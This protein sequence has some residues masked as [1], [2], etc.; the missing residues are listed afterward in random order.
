MPEPLVGAFMAATVFCGLCGYQRRRHRSAWFAGFWICSAFACLTKGLLG[1][2]YPATIFLLLSIFYREARLRYRA[3]LRW[4]YLAIFLLIAAPWHIWTQWKFPGY[5]HYLIVREWEGHLWGLSD[6]LRDY[7]GVPVYQFVLMH[8]AWWFPWSIALLPGMIFAW[9]RV[10]R[11]HEIYFGDAL[12]LCW[13]GV[14]FVPLLFLGQRQDYYSMSMWS[15]FALWAA[16]AWGR[17]PQRWRIAGTITVAVSGVVCAAAAFF[18]ARAARPLNG[19]WGTMD[20]RWTAW[21]ALHDM[22]VSAWLASWPLLAITGSSLVLFSLVALYFVFEQREKLAAIALAISM[23]PCGLAMMDGVARVAPYFSL[24]NVAR[25][26]N[27]RLEAGGDTIFEGPLEESSSL[28]FY[29]NRKF[30]LV[31]QNRQKAAPLGTPPVDIFLNEYAV[32]RK[33]AQPEAVYLIVEQS[34]ADYW[35]QLLTSRFHVYHQI[36]TSGTYVVLSNQL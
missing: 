36:I 20:A 10:M 13:M 25:F 16:V 22:P 5:F 30:F 3:L 31:N 12:L 4:E 21:R 27:P 23:V 35:K 26:L 11:P 24:A 32:L 15:A 7:L 9:R 8:L 34:R 2:V 19:N 6:D 28:V 18:L 14:V 1:L 33:W 29:L 17:M